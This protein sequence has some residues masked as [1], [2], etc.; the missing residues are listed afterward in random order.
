[1][2]VRHPER[3]LGPGLKLVKLPNPGSLRVLGAF[4]YRPVGPPSTS[5]N[6]PRIVKHHRTTQSLKSSLL[7]SKAQWPPRLFGSLPNISSFLE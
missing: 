6:L 1:M 3:D 5:G 7:Y 2:D 4:P